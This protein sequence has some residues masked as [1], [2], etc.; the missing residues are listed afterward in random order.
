M[1]QKRKAKESLKTKHIDVRL[2]EV[3]FEQIALKAKMSG[4]K[5]AAYLRNLGMNYPIKSTVNQ[6]ALSE[7]IKCRADLGVLRERLEDENMNQ[8]LKDLFDKENELLEIARKL[9]EK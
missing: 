2:S 1:S 9:L 5:N 3:E 6:L 4:L 8:F 7:L